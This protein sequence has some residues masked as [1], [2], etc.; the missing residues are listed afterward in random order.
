MSAYPPDYAFW[1]RERQNARYAALA[2]QKRQSAPSVA[3]EKPFVGFVSDPSGHVSWPQ[4]APMPT[5][6]APVKAFDLDFLPTSV[7]PWV[8]D[9]SERMQCPPD[10]V[11][12]PAIV[13]LG[14]VLGR[15]IGVRPQRRTDWIEVPNLWGCIVG[16]PGAMK[17]PAMGEALK[18]LN[19]LDSKAREVHL[20][21]LKGHA[22]KIELHKL[23]LDEARAAARKAFKGNSEALAFNVEEPD[24]PKARRYVVNDTTYEALGEILAD[25]PNGVLAY[26]DELVSLLKTLDREEYVAARGF[27]L[28]AWGGTASYTFDRIMRGKTHIEAACLSLLGSTQ[29]GRIA[30]YVRRATDGGSGDDGLIQRFGLLVWPDQE[31]EWRET[32]RYPNS[33]ARMNAW[34][35]FE[36]LDKL[37]PN[38]V[39]AERDQFEA[40]PLLRLDG[41]AQRTFSEWHFNLEIR[42]RGGAMPPALESHL[43]KYRKLVPAIALINHLADGGAGPISAPALARALAISEYLESHAGR[44]Y[45][46]GAMSEAATAKTILARTR[47]G[48]LQDGFAARD[49]RRREWSGLTDTGQIKAGLELLADYDWVASRT[50]EKRVAVP[51]VSTRSTPPLFDEFIFGAA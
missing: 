36:R 19:R 26:R 28:T 32:D 15:K 16:R 5:G 46:A 12:I 38:A 18:P 31:P 51:V 37:D 47:K 40:L 44:A 48:E 9:I 22:G 20:E 7:A 23:K 35:T 1:P 39:S 49:I 50:V 34:A 41:H 27:F 8:A 14:S 25:N 6:L 45:G 43:A 2:D 24:E 11:A 29:P 13:A 30:E 33:D 10:F 42:L 3:E 17:S 21:A 4:P